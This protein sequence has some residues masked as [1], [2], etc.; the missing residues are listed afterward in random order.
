MT[1]FYMEWK[2]FSNT[3]VKS[4]VKHHVLLKWNK[5]MAVAGDEHVYLKGK[6]FVDTPSEFY[7]TILSFI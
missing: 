5:Y 3:D 2:L 7:L 1:A 6:R 4:I